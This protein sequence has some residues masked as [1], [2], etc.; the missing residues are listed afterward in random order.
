MS[1]QTVSGFDERWANAQAASK[2]TPAV[3]QTDEVDISAQGLGDLVSAIARQ[4]HEKG[5]IGAL[6]RDKLV[7][8]GDE[9]ARLLSQ[10]PAESLRSILRDIS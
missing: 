6:E 10:V 8:C 7:E 3:D 2:Q 4:A 5:A 9:V 1:Q